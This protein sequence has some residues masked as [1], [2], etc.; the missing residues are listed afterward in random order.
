MK[1]QKERKSPYARH[2]KSEYQYSAKYWAWR[3]QFPM[4]ALLKANRGITRNED[5]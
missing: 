1:K 2:G 5:R 4:S 3:S